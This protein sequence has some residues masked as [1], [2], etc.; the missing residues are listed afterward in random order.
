MTTPCVWETYRQKI[1][2]A[3]SLDD[4]IER[5]Y[6]YIPGFKLSYKVKNGHLI[7]RRYNR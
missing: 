1:A 4:L 6:G 7:T 5:K 3:R 2:K